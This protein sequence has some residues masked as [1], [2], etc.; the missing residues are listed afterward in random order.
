MSAKSAMVTL[1]R[2]ITVAPGLF[3]PG[4]LGE[5]TW[6]APFEL[7]DALVS[8]HGVRERRVRSLPS[9]V[10]VYLVLAMGL[11]GQVSVAGVFAKLTAGLGSAAP[12]APSEK[13]LRDLRRRIGPAP[14]KALFEV[15]AGP[16]AQPHTPGVRYR[17]YRTVA[18]D[19]CSS[20][21]IP[22][23]GRNLERYGPAP[24]GAAVRGYPMLMLMTLAET[25]TR[26]LIGAVFG[27]ISTGEIAYAERLLH[28]LNPQML[29][30]DDRGFDSDEFL[31]KIAATGAQFLVRAR[32]LRRPP[33]LAILP[34]G[35]YLTLIAG[36]RL[37]VIEAE[38]TM[39]GQ[40]GSEVTGSYRLLTTL[41]DHRTDP[42]RTLIALYHER[43]EIESTY[44][45]IRHTLLHG[46][47]LRSK[48]PAGITQ[49]MWGLLACY[50]ALRTAMLTAAESAP[51]SDPDR[52]CF[53]LALE[54]TR[55]QVINAELG[56][57]HDPIG[58]TGR[59]LLAHPL[60]ARRPRY[61]ARK[62]KSPTSRYSVNN[63][64]QRPLASTTVTHL[65]ITILEPATAPAPA[66]TTRET[67]P[68]PDKQ[69]IL[70]ILRNHSG[71]PRRVRDIAASLE[72]SG[73]QPINRLATRMSRWARQGLLTKT[74]PATYTINETP[75]LTT[76]SN[77]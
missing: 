21:K 74:A 33:V 34:D 66:P 13:A 35:S 17:R 69:H 3:A 77:P 23:S 57:P 72:I 54:T 68:T 4:H 63:D 31:G 48:D 38:I 61:S 55:N 39:K 9:R 7:V 24:V 46:R 14:V 51:G 47:V 36:L 53:T 64:P 42:A 30:L 2:A 65:A 45:A 40:D 29:L 8:E 6:I 59:T 19:G 25:G 44:Y 32:A 62:V 20:T 12:P 56:D 28:L 58:A 37:R 5:L 10:G 18:F 16:L 67:G 1:A 26:A 22:E 27:P 15:L 50:Q 52:L 71:Q 49:E 11:F 76:R 60:P 75:P 73:R 41:L 70:D 43:W